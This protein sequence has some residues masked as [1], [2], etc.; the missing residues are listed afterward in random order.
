MI[1]DFAPRDQDVVRDL[2]L[3]GLEEHWGVLD[4]DLN[5]DLRDMA[6][7]YRTGRT[8]VAELEEAIVATGTLVRRSPTTAE[9][10]RMSV[11]PSSRRQ[12]LGKQIALELTATARRWGIKR[13]VL[14][15]SSHW[16]GAIAFYRRCG[17]S[18]THEQ[19]GAFGRDT[20]FELQL[21]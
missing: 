17:F 18:I 6:E 1:R 4:P 19:D 12:G 15:T 7:S 20:W 13:I 3:S 14:E 21:E 10:I 11:A 16:T 5:E 8:V 2:V 9:I